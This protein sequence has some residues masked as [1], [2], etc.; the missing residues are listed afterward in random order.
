MN[1][2]KIRPWNILS[3]SNKIGY[4]CYSNI[5]MAK[6]QHGMVNHFRHLVMEPKTRLSD[7]DCASDY[8]SVNQAS[9]GSESPAGK[10]R[11]PELNG[12]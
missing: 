8:L 3:L 1:A 6:D 5:K 7:L 11:K 9:E 2:L 4:T 12:A 10:R